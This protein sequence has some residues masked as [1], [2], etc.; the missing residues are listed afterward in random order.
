MLIFIYGEDS[1]RVQEKVK[2]MEAKFCE[3]F[4]P[5]GMNSARFNVQSLIGEIMQAVQTPP[6]LGEKRLTVIRDLVTSIKKAEAEN[7]VSSFKKTP[8]SSI[9]IFWETVATGKVEKSELFKQLSKEKDTHL[10]PFPLLKTNE[11][12]RWIATWAKEQKISLQKSA[13][14]ELALRVGADLWRLKSELQKL[15]AL[16]STSEITVQMV[17]ENIPAELEDQLF[18]FLDAVSRKDTKSAIKI[19]EDERSRGAEE[20]YLFS[21]LARQVRI[22]LGARALLDNNPRASK[23]DLATEMDLH[24]FVAQ[25]AMEQAKRF[26]FVDLQNTHQTLFAF[27]RK[28]KTGKITIQTANDLLVARLVQ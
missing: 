25:K 7:W 21:M 17:Q 10:Y 23:Q 12:E 19:L 16:A 8:E 15:K 14:S 18:A 13:S 5:S 1:F 9:V 22:L 6:F 4:D 28:I 3:K 26:S 11:I 27:D 20:I 2:E 24:P